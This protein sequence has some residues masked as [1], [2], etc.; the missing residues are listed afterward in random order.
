MNDH[1]ANWTTYW[2]MLP[3]AFFVSIIAN[4][5]GIGGS[6]FYSPIFVMFFPLIGVPTMS[7]AD[8]FGSAIMTV[9]VGFGSGSAAYAAR[10]LIDFHVALFCVIF[11]IPTAFL[12][13]Y[14]RRL[15]PAPASLYSFACILLSLV[16]I[17]LLIKKW[18]AAPQDE[19]I[20]LEN[21]QQV[22]EYSVAPIRPNTWYQF[23]TR[24]RIHCEADGN[25]TTYRIKN[26]SLLI[27]ASVIGG[28]LTG[29]VSVGAGELIGTAF[30]LQENFPFK[31]SS[32]TS[33]FI[34]FLTVLSSSIYDLLFI[35]VSSFPWKLLVWTMP[36]VLVGAQ[37]G[38][39]VA[40]RVKRKTWFDHVL[41]LIFVIVALLST[42]SVGRLNYSSRELFKHTD[43][44]SSRRG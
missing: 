20:A 8:A 39:F 5:F 14:L 35:G 38:S 22:A 33:L 23:I 31:I 37:V 7:P 28:L 2:F 10:S 29:F 11:T 30:L 1:L 16:I 12:G 42:I 9:A 18:R 25:C 32:G 17:R 40:S 15:V 24:E 13:A 4:L 34:V 19:A 6:V 21:L 36:A 41:T 27:A 44:L 3:T 26:Y 43:V